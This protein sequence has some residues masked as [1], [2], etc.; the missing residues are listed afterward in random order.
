[1]TES[2]CLECVMNSWKTLNTFITQMDLERIGCAAS[3]SSDTTFETF[4]FPVFNKGSKQNME[5]TE[6]Q[7][8]M[9]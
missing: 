4:P 2:I 6:Y 5:S 8:A 7:R 3:E 1:M 9:I